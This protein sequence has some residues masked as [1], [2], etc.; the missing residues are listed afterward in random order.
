M[1]LKANWQNKGAILT[2]QSNAGVTSRVTLSRPTYNGSAHLGLPRSSA[3]ALLHHSQCIVALVSRGVAEE[4]GSQQLPGRAHTCLWMQTG[5]STPTIRAKRRTP[6]DPDWPG[7][8]VPRKTSSSPQNKT[9]TALTSTH[10][11]CFGH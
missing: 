4:S 11:P 5:S 1:L 8:A 9:G 7:P 6:S 10:A 2:R 3:W